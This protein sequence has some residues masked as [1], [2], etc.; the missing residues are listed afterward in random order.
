MARLPAIGQSAASV[1]VDDP[2]A[3]VHIGSPAGQRVDEE[4]TLRFAKEPPVVAGAFSM[5]RGERSDRGV[6]SRLGLSHGWRD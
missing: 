2:D 3:G 6:W 1:D 4:A 5:S